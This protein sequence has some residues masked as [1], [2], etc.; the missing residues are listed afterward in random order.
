MIKRIVFLLMSA[1][2]FFASAVPSQTSAAG[3]NV[4]LGFVHSVLNN[5]GLVSTADGS[6]Y[7]INDLW[8]NFYDKR[9]IGLVITGT[10]LDGIGD[11]IVYMDYT[12]SKVERESIVFT[13]KEILPP[14]GA[15]YAPQ[16]QAKTSVQKELTLAEKETII[17]SPACQALVNEHEKKTKT[18]V[19]TF[20]RYSVCAKLINSPQPAN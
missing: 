1:F 4:K 12:L 7:L 17:N 2:V 19:G 9:E 10:G 14:T 16:P 6:L 18:T 5:V 15:I 8:I 13:A 20:G 3:E 11:K